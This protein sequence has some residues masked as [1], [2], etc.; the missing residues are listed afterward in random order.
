MKRKYQVNI[1]YRD[2]PDA[3]ETV[4][5]IV[6]QAIKDGKIKLDNIDSTTD[7]ETA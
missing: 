4:A 2:K 1:H 7:E 5:Q 3:M 6:A